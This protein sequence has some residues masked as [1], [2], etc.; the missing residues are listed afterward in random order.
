MMRTSHD[1]VQ[2]LLGEGP[3]VRLTFLIKHTA[4]PDE[5]ILAQYVT[6]TMLALIVLSVVIAAVCGQT[7]PPKPHCCTPPQWSAVVTNGGGYA[8]GKTMG[9]YGVSMTLTESMISLL[10]CC[11]CCCGCYCCCCCCCCYIWN[12]AS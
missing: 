4:Y 10:C 5:V 6:K 3:S 9:A 1:E 8:D 2:A 12:V 11:C 7:P